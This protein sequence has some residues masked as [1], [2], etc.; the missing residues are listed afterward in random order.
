MVLKFEDIVR[1]MDDETKSLDESAKDVTKRF[2][3][4]KGS[5]LNIL[6]AKRQGFD[7]FNLYSR[8]LLEKRGFNRWIDYFNEI[9]KRRGFCGASDYESYI[10]L[11]N[12]GLVNDEEEYFEGNWRNKLGFE[13]IDPKYLDKLPADRDYSFTGILEE[14]RR[15]VE[16]KVPLERAISKLSANY[17]KVII[18]RFYEGKTLREM[19]NELKKSKD[20][21]RQ[22]EMKS[23]KK[24]FWLVKK[25][26]LELSLN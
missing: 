21:I 12:K 13:Y 6:R 24:L 26:G 8:N 10:N 2:R 25:Q 18:G 3:I 22:I 16:I 9:T 5:A 14:E 1:A 19:G 4:K 15:K 23:L 7:S 20:R 17:Q 11:K